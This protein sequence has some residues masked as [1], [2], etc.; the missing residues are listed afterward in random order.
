VKTFRGPDPKPA[1]RVKDA[2]ALK[3]VH[4]RGCVCALNCGLPGEAHHVLPRSQG[5]DDV[6]ANLVCLCAFHHQAV[7]ANDL[8]ARTDLGDYVVLLRPDVMA[9]VVAK[10]GDG[11][12]EWLRRRL[13]IG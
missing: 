4:A 9:Y 8:C 11:G 3:A 6:E 7:H 13:L 10:L 12:V 1:K 2:K 5:G